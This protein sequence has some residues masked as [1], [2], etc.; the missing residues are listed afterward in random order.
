MEKYKFTFTDIANSIDYL[1]KYEPDGWKSYGVNFGREEK[2]SNVVK[3]YTNDWLF[4]KEDADYL[5]DIVLTR[6]TETKIKLTISKLQLDGWAVQYEGY[7]DLT[8]LSWD[9]N[10]C[11]APITEGGFFKTLE[12]NWGTEYEIDNDSLINNFNGNIFSFDARLHSSGALLNYEVP[13]DPE[14][15]TQYV[16][17]SLGTIVDKNVNENVLFNASIPAGYY[18]Y[19]GGGVNFV[20]AIIKEPAAHL[21]KISSGSIMQKFKINVD[22]DISITVQVAS[23]VSGDP[24]NDYDYV[25]S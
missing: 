7:V 2:L 20:R 15:M 12:A 1:L 14:E 6:G 13:L 9:V 24:I 10:T 22:I 25:Y 8:Q 18:T 23:R 3:S 19:I 4:I 5:R 11:S 17:F 21:L 16:S